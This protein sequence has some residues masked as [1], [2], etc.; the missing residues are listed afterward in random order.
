MRIETGLIALCLTLSLTACAGPEVVTE[1]R[2]VEIPVET[3][4]DLPDEALA[5]CPTP[6]ACLAV[7]TNADLEQC[8]VLAL[9]ALS[10]C[11]GQITEI[12]EVQGEGV[13][14]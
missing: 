4:R 9:A 13:S 2:T 10:Q 12:R 7:L 1:T 5:E 11:D 3:Y 8:A 14:K 6:P